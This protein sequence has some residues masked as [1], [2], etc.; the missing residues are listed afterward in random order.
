MRPGDRIKFKD[1]RY[2]D[3]SLKIAEIHL[4]CDC[5]LCDLTDRKAYELHVSTCAL[6]NDYVLLNNTDY[7][8]LSEIEK[9]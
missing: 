5:L 7:V 6:R 9:I 3:N 4:N 1:N 2:F 8:K